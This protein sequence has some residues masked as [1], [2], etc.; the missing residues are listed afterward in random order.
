MSRAI[1]ANFNQYL[2]DQTSR[3]TGVVC[4]GGI[5]PLRTDQDPTSLW[6]K[7]C[8][9]G[10]DVMFLKEAVATRRDDATNDGLND[11]A[12]RAARL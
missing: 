6:W 5:M 7:N 10:E 9:R 1:P 12:I 2:L 8:I 3:N 4:D 11:L